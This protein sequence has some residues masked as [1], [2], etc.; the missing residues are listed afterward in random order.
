MKNQK[1]FVVPL[2][3][4]IVVVL[5]G[6]DIYNKSKGEKNTAQ[7]IAELQQ[8]SEIGNNLKTFT[9]QNGLYSLRYPSD[10][11]YTEGR[12]NY[13]AQFTT[14]NRETIGI[15]LVPGE[16]ESLKKKKEIN[17]DEV[18]I[19]SNKFYKYTQTDVYS[20]YTV[21]VLPIGN[22]SYLSF[23]RGVFSKIP[24]ADLNV[25]L[26]SVQVYPAKVPA[27]VEKLDGAALN[28]Q[29]RA[30]VSNFRVSAEMYFDTAKTYVGICEGTNANAKAVVID[31][32]LKS[33]AEA[34]SSANVYCKAS[35]TAFIYSARIPDGS[36]ICIDNN[37]LVTKISSQPTG[38]SCK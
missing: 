38:W 25:F 7:E 11:T 33:T 16:V 20:G 18:T 37:V 15:S 22:T 10:W 13:A 26:G 36:A 34:V 6:V 8:E 5:V 30:N 19:G 9:Q 1:G 29:L 17:I 14:T 24:S 2:L 32:I 35:A 27:A 4:A 23:S 3:I 12:D 28:A 21:Y 31:K